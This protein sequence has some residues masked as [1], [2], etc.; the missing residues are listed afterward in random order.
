MFELKPFSPIL[1]LQREKRV[2]YRCSGTIESDDNCPR[3]QEG[4]GPNGSQLAEDAGN[5]RHIVF[6]AEKVHQEAAFSMA[7]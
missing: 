4:F 6:Q 1:I 3:I 5:D 7:L 2:A